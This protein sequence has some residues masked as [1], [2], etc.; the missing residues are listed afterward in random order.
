MKL[1]KPLEDVDSKSLENAI[2]IVKKLKAAGYENTFF[3][4]GYVRDMLLG[5]DSAKDIDIAT[6]AK[7][8]EVKSVL[9]GEKFI[10]VGESFNIVMA[11]IDGEQ[12]E[13]ATFRADSS[14][15]SDGRRPD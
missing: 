12:F 10:E 8:E 4:G 14:E 11:I 6:E 7:P 15:Y 13:I 5:L 2:N 1:S 3:V 9:A